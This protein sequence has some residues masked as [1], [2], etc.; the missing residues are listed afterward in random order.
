MESAVAL[1]ANS[2]DEDIDLRRLIPFWKFNH[3][4]VNIQ[5]VGL[6]TLRAFEVHMV[7][8]VAGSAARF[9]AERV[10]Q[11]TLIVK[12]FMD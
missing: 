8:V 3:R 10:L 6:T 5:A 9:V 12:N 7:M 4:Y 11:T 1:L 2:L